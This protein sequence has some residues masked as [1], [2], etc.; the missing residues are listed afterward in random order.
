MWGAGV[1]INI[2]TIDHPTPWNGLAGNWHDQ[3]G[4]FYLE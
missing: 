1:T 4:V 3:V 2:K